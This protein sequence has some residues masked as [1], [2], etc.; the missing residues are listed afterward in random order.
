MKKI[1]FRGI[2]IDNGE[3]IYGFYGY[4]DETETAYIM[5]ETIN[6]HSASYFTEY[7]VE[8][9]TVGQYTGLHD[10]NGKEIYEGDITN[11]GIIYW[12]NES[13]SFRLKD[14]HKKCWNAFDINIL[15]TKESPIYGYDTHDINAYTTPFEV[16]GN[17]YE[18]LELVEGVR[19]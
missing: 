12:E 2:R 13:C 18:N 14:T 5:V 4:K 8:P 3:W 1:K 9:E 17:I 19:E 10:K 16:F 6:T 7:E 11:H 15:G